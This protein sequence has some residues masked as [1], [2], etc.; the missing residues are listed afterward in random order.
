MRVI[1]AGSQK[2][3]QYLLLKLKCNEILKNITSEITIIS[4]DANGADKLGVKYAKEKGYK[5]KLYPADWDNL[6]A[7]GAIVKVNST[8][9]SY[10][11][12][13]G[14]DRNRKMA[15]NA[16]AL[17]A[18]WNGYSH[19]TKNMIEVAK[20]KKLLIRIIKFA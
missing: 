18:F 3:E 6:S 10:N 4:G 7:P 13:A 12:K 14:I 17:I 9:K 11:A 19:G 8:G 20:E 5:F 1:I 15:D 16:D 2:F